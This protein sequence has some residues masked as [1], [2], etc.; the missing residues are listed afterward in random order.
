[1][2]KTRRAQYDAEFKLQAI[3]KAIAKGNRAAAL[4]LGINES[5]VRRWRK[6]RGDLA[7]SKKSTKAVGRG[8]KNGRWPELEDEIEHWV[9]IQREQGRGVSTV[10]IRL[11]AITIAKEKKIDDFHGGASWCLRFMRRKELTVRARTT[12]CQQLPPDF[13]DKLQNFRN[14]TQEHISENLIGPQDLINMDE[15]PLTFDLPLTRTVDNTGA[16]TV[17]IKTSGHEKTS[18]T[19]VLACTASG[20][21]LPPM[22]IFKRI[23]MP[24]EKFPKG[25]VVKTNKKGWMDESMMK[26]WLTECYGQRPGGFFRRNKAMLVMDSM[27]AHTTDSVKEAI[28]ATNSIPAIIPGGTTKYL[29]PLDISVNR[30]FK[31]QMRKK[32]GRVDDRW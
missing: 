4:E 11:K 8:P 31:V 10:Q 26:A 3:E 14:Y 5:M 20:Q 15:V 24:K 2:P 32:M 9:K 17:T 30:P 12:I 6:Q 28:K 22:V 13:E 21:K 7:R 19:C 1:M 16:S 25:I 23:T 29:Q 27:R 18:F